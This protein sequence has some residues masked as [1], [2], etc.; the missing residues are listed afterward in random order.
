MTRQQWINLCTLAMVRRRPDVPAET[1]M[2][3][4]ELM[5]E[6]TPRSSPQR[7]ATVEV[8]ATVRKAKTR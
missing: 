7:A 2:L 4:A 5:H 6:D 1:L 3:L 8:L